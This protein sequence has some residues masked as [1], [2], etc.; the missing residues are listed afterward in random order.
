MSGCARA[1]SF[2]KV[3]D[4]GPI[5][6]MVEIFCDIGRCCLVTDSNLNPK[7]LCTLSEKF[8]FFFNEKTYQSFKV[9]V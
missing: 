1:M 7:I 2:K 3:K 6:V 9:K 5:F 8:K 4:I